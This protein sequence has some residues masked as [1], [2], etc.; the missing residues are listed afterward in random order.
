MSRSDEEQ[1]GE[2]RSRRSRAGEA[3]SR[4]SQLADEKLLVDALQR[5]NAQAFEELVR[6]NSGRMLA[7]TRRILRNEE[8]ARDAVQDAFLNGFQKIGSFERGSLVSTW[9]H[10]I[11]V[12]AALMKLRS[13]RRKPEEPLDPLLPSFLPDG[14]R[15]DPGPAWNPDAADEI[16]RRRL[17]ALVREQIDHLPETYRS[18]LLL[19]DVEGLSTE[20]AATALGIGTDAV[21]MRLHR[22]RQ[23]LR[24]L[25]DPHMRPVAV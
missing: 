19:R 25:L 4:A 6:T 21:K 14:H 18:V 15:A 12:N 13:R 7:V 11:A 9:L 8:D 20:E 3:A 10:R 16:D 17:L 23:G 22:A 2:R 24:T 5:G 1:A